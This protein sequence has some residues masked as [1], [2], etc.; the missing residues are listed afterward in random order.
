MSVAT[1][2][3]AGSAAGVLAGIPPI[4]AGALV[5]VVLA[6]RMPQP[7]VSAM[8]SGAGLVVGAWMLRRSLQRDA[9]RDRILQA[10][11]H[12]A[13]RPTSRPTPETPLRSRAAATS[14]VTR[15]LLVV[16]AGFSFSL[17]DLLVSLTAYGTLF[18]TSPAAVYN[19][20][21]STDG[22]D[23]AYDLAA[24]RGLVLSF[25]VMI[26][27]A[28]WFAHRL[29]GAARVGLYIAIAMDTLGTFAIDLHMERRIGRH[30]VNGQDVRWL[31][32]G[33]LASIIA[34]LIGRRLAARTQHRFDIVQ[35]AQ[36]E[37]T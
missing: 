34:C 20:V 24:P 2:S 17:M 15:T 6:G 35:A 21:L 37:V 19:S 14:V 31:L 16:T 7:A 28:I 10:E 29:R 3:P 12:P 25:L 32:L 9:R 23:A 27:V 13:S 1:T 4:V 36:A 11:P 18:Y 5:E 22:S 30:W 8:S 26:P 33:A